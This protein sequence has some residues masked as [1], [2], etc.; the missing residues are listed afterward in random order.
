MIPGKQYTPDDLVAILSRRKWLLIV[1]TVLAAVATLAFTRTLPNEY[2]SE[3]IIM[4]QPPR[5]RQDLV[6]SSVNSSSADRIQTITQQILSRTRLE[7]IITDLNLYATERR[8]ALM[9]DVIEKM[10]T[11]V[12]VQVIRGDAFRVAYDSDSPITAMKVTERLGRLFI[13]ENLRDREMLAEGT[14]QF[15]E[16]QLEDA[17]RRLVDQEKKLEQYRRL[18]AGEMPSQQESNLTAISNL[19]MQAQQLAESEARDRDRLQLIE[20]QLADLTTPEAINDDA[21]V[22]ASAGTVR[23]GTTAQQ[24]AAARA[25]LSQLQLRLTPEHP[26]IVRMKRVIRDLEKK[27]DADAAEAPVSP[28][29]TRPKTP[30]EAARRARVR[31]LQED[32]DGLRKAIAEKADEQ[33]R[34]IASANGYQ[35]HADAAPTRETELIELMRD[36]DTIQKMYTG[37]LS[38]NEESKLAVNLETRQIGEQFRILDP[39]RVPEKPFSPN[40]LRLNSAGTAIGLLLGAGLIMFLE[41]RDTTLKSDH[42]V[43]LAL[44]LPVLALVPFMHTARDLR[45]ARL[46]KWALGIAGVASVGLAIAAYWVFKV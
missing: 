40:R 4:V 11:D 45:R 35:A 44:S 17:R 1:P 2:R 5:V 27:A 28:E 43:K 29:A 21:V 13:D 36:Y 42:D 8:T 30:A 32:A 15:L 18:H 20:R 34:L 41:W 3:T 37:L 12:D 22:D 9:E 16:S 46:R 7:A 6:K 26:D 10:R 19:H 38:K 39:A 23:G 31:Q 33:K 24:L 14:S 25:V